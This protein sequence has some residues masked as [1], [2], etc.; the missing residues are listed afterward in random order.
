MSFVLGRIFLLLFFLTGSIMLIRVLGHFCFTKRCRN[1]KY[2]AKGVLYSAVALLATTTKA[3]R[4][5]LK[6]LFEGRG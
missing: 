3:G 6:S 2:L 5:T 4:K 1:F